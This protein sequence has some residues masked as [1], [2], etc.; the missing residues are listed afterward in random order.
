MTYRKSRQTQQKIIAAAE[1]L[2]YE[3]G[4]ADTLQQEVADLAGINRGLIYHYFKTKE[5]I[6]VIIFQQFISDFSQKLRSEILCGETDEVVISITSGRVL[7]RYLMS[8]GELE[9]FYNQIAAQS[10]VT[11]FIE[12][13]VL[14]DLK[15][16][17]EF[18]GVDIPDVTMQVY[19]GILTGIEANILELISRKRTEMPVDDVI[20][21]YNMLHLSLLNLTGRQRSEKIEKSIELADSI[22]IT[23]KNAFAAPIMCRNTSGK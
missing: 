6:A 11:Q 22:V 20:S 16:E 8:I 19:A 14:R 15:G 21:I 17:A 7:F 2:F 10:E 23:P 1:K 13:E 18:C 9:R 5:A 3:K 4:V 12:S